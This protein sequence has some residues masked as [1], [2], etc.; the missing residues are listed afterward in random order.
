[1]DNS[2]NHQSLL[3]PRK[4]TNKLLLYR[5]KNQKTP[6]TLIKHDDHTLTAAT[7][8]LQ[9]E[10]DKTPGLLFEPGVKPWLEWE[11]ARGEQKH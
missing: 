7:T 3:S 2:F 6:G 8:N 9:P 1:M 4:V 11:E 10:L 5:Q